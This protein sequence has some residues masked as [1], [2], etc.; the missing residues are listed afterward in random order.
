MRQDKI[1]Y[2]NLLIASYMGYK[3]NAY[4]ELKHLNITKPNESDWYF[5]SHEKEDFD[6]HITEDIKYHSSWDWLMPVIEKIEDNLIGVNIY[7]LYTKIMNIHPLSDMKVIAIEPSNLPETNKL[8][9][10]YKAVVTF[11]EY[12]NKYYPPI[13]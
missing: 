1:P 3:F 2:G 9:A 10:T 5:A 13:S 4:P 7:S 8:E 12:H 6:R 11:V